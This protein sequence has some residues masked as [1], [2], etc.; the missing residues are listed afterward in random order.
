[1]QFPRSVCC[2]LRGQLWC[3]FR[4][5]QIFRAKPPSTNLPSREVLHMLGF[6][7]QQRRRE[8]QRNELVV[9]AMRRDDRRKLPMSINERQPGPG[10]AI[11]ISYDQRSRVLIIPDK[12]A[13]LAM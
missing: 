12:K 1:M 7:G 9:G 10:I 13:G 6:L 3:R 5:S 4:P 2:G 8:Q 11:A